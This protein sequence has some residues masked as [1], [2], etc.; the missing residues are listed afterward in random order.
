MSIVRKDRTRLDKAMGDDTLT[1]L[2]LAGA[3][4]SDAGRIHDRAI[5]AVTE[6][7][8][9]PFLITD[10]T[11]LTPQERTRWFS[12]VDQ[13]YAVVGGDARAVVERGASSDLLTQ[14]GDP[15]VM[16]IRVAYAA[17]DEA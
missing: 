15:S 12:D 1:L 7:W 10:Q 13:R 9:K 2:L 17:G 14:K 4:S 8:R 3:E 6:S 16:A 5:E 11:V